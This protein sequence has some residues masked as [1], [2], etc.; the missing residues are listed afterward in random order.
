MCIR[1]SL[2]FYVSFFLQIH[3]RYRF[4]VPRLG[5]RVF[6]RGA[7]IANPR[8]ADSLGT[9]EMP[10]R[11]IVKPVKCRS[12]NLVNPADRDTFRILSLIHI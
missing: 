8:A 10:K 6:Q 1:D 5:K 4:G 3:N 11:D 12:V 7:G 9:M 2:Y